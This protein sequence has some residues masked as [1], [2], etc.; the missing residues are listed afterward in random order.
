MSYI[1]KILIPPIAGV[2]AD[3][4]RYEVRWG[5]YVVHRGIT[6]DL[7]RRTQEHRRTWPGCIVS[8]LGPL[9]TR[10]EA[11]AWERRNGY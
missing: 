9:V 3:T 6:G 5:G 11:L 8:R 2:A 7:A 1:S 10:A 4:Y